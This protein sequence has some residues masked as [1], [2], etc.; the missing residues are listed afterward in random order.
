MKMKLVMLLVAVM[1]FM[2][3][4]KTDACT[5]I[6]LKAKDGTTVVA[7]TI[8]WGGS[9]LNSQYVVVP[10][11]YVQYSYLPGGRTDGMKMGFFIFLS[12]ANMKRLM[13]PKRQQAYPIC[14]WFPG[15]WVI[16]KPSMR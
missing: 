7:R 6:T 15:Y 9:E 3:I 11:G 1:P 13:K 10:R 16:F 12:M 4:A 5:G 8:E 2:P 14:N